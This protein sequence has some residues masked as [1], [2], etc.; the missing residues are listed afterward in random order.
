MFT[1]TQEHLANYA[2]LLA[3]GFGRLQ[4]LSCVLIQSLVLGG[5]GIL[6]GSVGFF[7]ACHASARTPI[8]LETTP[9]VFA[10]LVLLSTL[11]SVGSSYLSMRAIF[12]L[13]PVSV[14]RA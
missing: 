8:P 13:D 7:A 11:F 5:L 9:A 1:I 3:L 12:S 6:L 4:L 14:F 10:S 2:T